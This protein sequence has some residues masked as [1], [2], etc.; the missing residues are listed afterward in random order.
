MEVKIGVQRAPREVSINT[1]Q[2]REDILETVRRAT[3]G[4][5]L[6]ELSDERGRTIAVPIARIAYLEFEPAEGRSVGFDA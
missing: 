2:S 3:N 4:D 6:L 5:E 1:T